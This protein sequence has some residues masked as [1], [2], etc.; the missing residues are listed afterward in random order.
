MKINKKIL[1]HFQLCASPVDKKGYLCIKGE[2]NTSYQKRWFVLKA[3]VL[4]YKERHN[5][6]DLVGVI[7]LEGGPVQ[8]CESEEQFAFRFYTTALVMDLK[9]QYKEA[10]KAIPGNTSQQSRVV[11]NM[12]QPTQKWLTIGA[13][14]FLQ[15]P[16]TA[17]GHSSTNQMLKTPP[18]SSKPANKRSP[19]LWS[20]KNANVMPI[21]GPTPPQGEWSVIGSFSELHEDYGKEVKKLISE[22]SG[23]GNEVVCQEEDLIDFG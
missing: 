6:R 1:T 22:W 21:I 7:V 10:K 5:N 11:P 12:E 14:S 15:Y 20:K 9:K 8:L 19:K 18:I 23:R 3:N 17:T 4:F 13:S 2:R 16:G